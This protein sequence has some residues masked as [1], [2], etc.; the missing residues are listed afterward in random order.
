VCDL[1]FRSWY[2]SCKTSSLRRQWMCTSVEEYIAYITKGCSDETTPPIPAPPPG[3]CAVVN[4]RCEFSTSAPTCA[5]RQTPSTMC[6][7]LCIEVNSTTKNNSNECSFSSNPQPESLCVPL[8]GKCRE[9]NPCRYWKNT[10]SSLYQCGTADDY[11]R[12]KLGPKPPYCA[13][14][15][16]GV[17]RPSGPCTLQNNTCLWTGK[18]N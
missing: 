14:I 13:Q 4:D 16:Q 6:Q 8:N 11:Y 1:L 2:R 7:Y 15:P 9:Y 10:C 5:Y 3:Q 18:F 12:S 17:S